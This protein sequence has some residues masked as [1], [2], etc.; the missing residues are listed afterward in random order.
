MIRKSVESIN[1]CQQQ[2]NSCGLNTL[3]T[4]SL[5]DLVEDMATLV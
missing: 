3:N 1:Q 5:Q 4:E 2:G